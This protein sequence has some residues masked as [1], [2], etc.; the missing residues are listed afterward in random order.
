M[1]FRLRRLL[2]LGTLPTLMTACAPVLKT[3][4][5][6]PVRA[7]LGELDVLLHIGAFQPA[8]QSAG[9]QQPVTGGMRES[10]ERLLPALFVKNGMRLKDFKSVGTSAYRAEMLRATE[11][12]DAERH[13]LLIESEKYQVG[14]AHGSSIIFE[15]RL[16]DR[17]TR[18][19]VW[20]A[21][22]EYVVEAKKPNARAEI[23]VRDLLLS[24]AKDG[25]I[26]LPAEGPVDLKGRRI[27]ISP[28]WADER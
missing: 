1:F 27:E 22:V 20:R 18:R 21:S 10:L 7:P 26:V 28:V 24:L 12:G 17:K 19:S 16:I 9:P 8:T 3:E 6:Q 15:T 5:I 4:V 13:L 2:L 11:Q 25:L 14:A 23:F